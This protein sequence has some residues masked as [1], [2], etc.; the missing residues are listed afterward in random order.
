MKN[1]KPSA[2]AE[3]WIPAL[4]HFLR[5]TRGVEAVR[6]DAEGTTLSVATLGEVDEALL[7][8]KLRETLLNAG[9]KDVVPA[10]WGWDHE[11]KVW[12]EADGLHLEKP[13]CATAPR[14]WRW[15]EMPWPEVKPEEEVTGRIS[16]AEEDWRWLAM[17]AGLCG[18]FGLTGL[19]LELAGLGADWLPVLCFGVA[20]LAGGWDAARDVWEN[21]PRGKMDIH[22]LMLAVAGGAAAI[23]AWGEGALLLF[24]FS[25]SGALEHYALHRTKREVQSLFDAAPRQARVVGADGETVLTPVEQVTPGTL[26]RV[27]PGDAFPLD[28][29]VMEGQTAADESTLTGEA[30]P[31][32]KGAGDE[33]FGGT[34]NLWGA[35]TARVLRPARESS[36]QKIIRLIREAQEQK[37]PSQSFTDRFGTRYTVGILGL[38]F[39]MFFVWWLGFG[40]R[41]FYHEPDATS[42]FYRAM[43]LLVVASPCALVLSIPSAILA[44]IAW[45]ARKGILFRGGAAIEGL[46]E[47]DLVALDKTGTLTTGE[48]VVERVESFP[49]G[50][51]R[52]V[53]ELAVAL[54]SRANHPI[55]RA[56]VHFGR[57]EKVPVLEVEAFRSLTGR[58]VEGRTQGAHCILGRRELLEEGPLKGWIEK[59]PEPDPE[60]VEVWVIHEELIGRLL[61]KDQIRSKS[62]EA[63]EAMRRA[64]LRTVMLTG[65][66]RGAAER[67]AA[68]LGV[69]AVEAGLSPRD[70]VERIQ[71]WAREGRRTAMVGDG[72]NDAPSLAA[73]DVAVAMG[74]RGSDAALEQSDVVLMHDRIENFMEAYFL[75]RRARAVIRQN[76]AVALGT[77]IIMV[78]AA[79][80]GVIPLSVGVFAHE[81]STVAVCLNSLRLLY[82]KPQLDRKGGK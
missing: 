55:A 18:V 32:G 73:A 33:V 63:L 27:L 57:K 44:A 71:G 61:L 54:E 42:A 79:L 60:Y 37:A 74:A 21:L 47:V 24:L 39:L 13:T 31:V 12:S 68:D 40:A 52:A 28:A 53:L 9:M 49:P 81:G 10:S 20:M 35:V 43:T 7:R 3:S 70:K 2:S 14:F 67:V 65:D 36:L 56:V 64:G 25:L 30:T 1:D 5:E 34:L 58:G 11:L 72:V 59:L 19:V 78:G 75:S 82:R 51:E 41:P 16:A 29:V 48:M 69:D 50:R 77:V 6:L 38:T 62:R 66:R 23:G 15:R 76:I 46:A 17:L 45:G 80:F 8:E 22:F 4:A 26:T